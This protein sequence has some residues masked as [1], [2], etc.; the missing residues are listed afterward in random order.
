MRMPNGTDLPMQ[1]KFT[2]I[3]AP[4][5]IV[6]VG[7][8]HDGNDVETTVTFIEGGGKTT[9]TARQTYAFESDSTRGAPQGWKAT[10][11]QLGEYV[12]RP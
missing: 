4:E 2:E 3:V 5:K 9:L 11:D 10:L 1:A 7:K 8:I 12:T 6:F